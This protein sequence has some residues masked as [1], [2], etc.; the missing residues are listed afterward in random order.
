MARME[1]HQ[2]AARAHALLA[3]PAGH[4]ALTLAM[5]H[6]PTG[7]SETAVLLVGEGILTRKEMDRLTA[8]TGRQWSD[9][10]D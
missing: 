7:W 2:L 5:R 3:S 4:Q 10:I 8:L 1:V 9:F 6:D